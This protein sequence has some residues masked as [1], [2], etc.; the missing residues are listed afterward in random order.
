AGGRPVRTAQ[1][2][3]RRR[4]EILNT[5]H[6]AMGPWPPLLDRPKVEY[7]E[8]ERRDGLTQHRLR[9]EVAPGRTTE[10]AY[11]LLPDGAGPFPAALVVFYDAGTGIG[12]GKAPRRDFA[13]QLARRGFVALSLGSA[14]ATFYPD[15]AR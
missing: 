8:K 12:R 1:E 4:Q 2:W 3:P 6:A 7:S 9:L 15:K 14:P 5:W 11:L 13:Y 10:D